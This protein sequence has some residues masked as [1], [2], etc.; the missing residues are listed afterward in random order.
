MTQTES[1]IEGPVGRKRG[2]RK[3]TD[4]DHTADGARRARI[5]LGRIE[6]LWVNTGTLCNIACE[7]CYIESSPTNDR[8][9]YFRH[10]DLVGYLDEIEEAGLGTKEIGF[11]G[12]EPFMNPDM[13]QMLDEALG[14]G[15]HV[16]VLTN[17][18]K[19][20][21]HKKAAL[22]DLRE[23]YRERLVI[24]VSLD[25]YSQPR[26]EEERGPGS[27][28]PTVAGLQWLSENGFTVHVA[29]RTMWGEDE[30]SLRAGYA[31]F[32]AREHIA[33][34]AANPHTLVLFPEMDEEADVPEITERCWGLLGVDP[35]DIM[36]ASS[37]MVVR[38][39]GRERPSVLACTLI[40]YDLRF[41][42]GETLADAAGEVALNHP[43]CARFCV[44][45]GGS[46]SKA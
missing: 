31:A 5:A 12:G 20:M 6:T 43:H 42:L 15:Y 19:P 1:D 33:V 41:E 3:F 37:R 11:T 18:M 24:R 39:Q 21:A 8:L 30:A 9:A 23:R 16:L 28:A 36:C 40:A 22:L 17:A 2:L 29:G 44:L 4:P 7:N 35:A 26:H 34:D 14:R 32:F 46:C 45:G 27:W 38:R 25:H 13:I 10:K